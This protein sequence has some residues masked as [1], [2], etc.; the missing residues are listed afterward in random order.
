MGLGRNRGYGEVRCTLSE[1]NKHKEYKD[2]CVPDEDIDTLSYSIENEDNIILKK[3][4][5][6]GTVLQGYFTGCMV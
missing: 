2:I 6:S 4:Y 1:Y 5:I 3:P